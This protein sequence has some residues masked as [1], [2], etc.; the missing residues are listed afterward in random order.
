MLTVELA[1]KL[2]STFYS[3]DYSDCA[4]H[5]LVGLHDDYVWQ[6]W[7]RF[8]K[9]PTQFWGSLDTWNQQNFVDWVNSR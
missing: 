2:F 3:A 1:G 5:M 7:L 8:Q 6:M 9:S 4:A